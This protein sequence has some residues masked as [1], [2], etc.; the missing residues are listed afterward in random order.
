MIAES[1]LTSK[2]QTT[3][4]KAVVDSLGVKPSDKLVFEIHAGKVTL[5][6]RTGRLADLAG[7]FR[8]FG[9][10]RRKKA[11][12]QEEM[13]AAVRRGAGLA[14]LRSRGASSRQRPGRA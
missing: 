13:D 9:K 1:T 2:N 10:R 5:S 3:L 8:H 7:A 12:G 6:A 14:H 11:P 4:P